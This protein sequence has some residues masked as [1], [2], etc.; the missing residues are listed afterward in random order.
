MGNAAESPGA[1]DLMR[2]Y[3]KQRA[4]LGPLFYFVSA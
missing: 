1:L 2:T 3:E 4:L